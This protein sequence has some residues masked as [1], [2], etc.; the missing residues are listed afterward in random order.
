MYK[1]IREIIRSRKGSAY[2][3]KNETK[4]L[5]GSLDIESIR[6]RVFK[7]YGLKV[8]G[9]DQDVVNQRALVKAYYSYMSDKS[10]VS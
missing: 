9:S 6:N 1:K 3:T 5:L 10:F 8:E 4:D 7:L 2:L